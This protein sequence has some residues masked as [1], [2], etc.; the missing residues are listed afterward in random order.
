MCHFLINL[1][2]V[3]ILENSFFIFIFIIEVFSFHNNSYK[4]NY[5]NTNKL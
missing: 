2:N 5:L 1:G 3:L 4:I